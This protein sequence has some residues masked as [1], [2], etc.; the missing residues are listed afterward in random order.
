MLFSSIK[1]PED[2][3]SHCVKPLLFSICYA[4]KLFMVYIGKLNSNTEL[5]IASMHMLVFFSTDCIGF[6]APYKKL[7]Y[8]L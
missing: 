4:C 5:F 7:K 1:T 8:S 2:G 6:Q 3:I